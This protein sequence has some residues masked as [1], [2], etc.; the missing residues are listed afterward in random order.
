MR[1]LDDLKSAFEKKGFNLSRTATYYRLLPANMRHKDEK[2][3]V[4][5]VPVKLQ[6]PQN[7]LRKKHPDGHFAMESVMFTK[8]LANLFGDNHVFFLSQYD[9]AR[10]PLGLPISKKQTT[11]LMHLEYKVTLPDH[12]FLIGEKHK[13]IPSVYAACLKKDGEVSYNGPTFI[14]IRSGK[15]VKSCE[16]T[17]SD[18]FQRIL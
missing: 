5:T 11:I 10:V 17:H 15:H 13:L 3:H 12:D 4:H 7:D 8:E 6:R 2:R 1:A 16:E 14:S 18:D 9:K